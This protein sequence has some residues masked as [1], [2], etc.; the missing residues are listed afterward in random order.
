VGWLGWWLGWFGQFV[1]LLFG[2]FVG[3]YVGGLAMTGSLGLFVCWVL[4]VLAT[5]LVVGLL[6]S[7]MAAC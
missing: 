5:C 6:L 2:N 4:V 3:G 1:A 7:W